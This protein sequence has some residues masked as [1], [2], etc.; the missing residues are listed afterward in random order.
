MRPAFPI[1]PSP[2]KFS[3]PVFAGLRSAKRTVADDPAGRKSDPRVSVADV[4]DD[5]PVTLEMRDWKKFCPSARL[6]APTV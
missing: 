3:T 6:T 1:V 2:P 5:A 4:T